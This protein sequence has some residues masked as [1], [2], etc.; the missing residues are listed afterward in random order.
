V[1]PQP[2][3]AGAIASNFSDSYV[4]P[5]NVK[6]Q[7]GYPGRSYEKF[8]DPEMYFIRTL[9]RRKLR[10]IQHYDYFSNQSK[11]KGDIARKLVVST[12]L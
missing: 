6:C 12:A 10:W 5:P 9:W 3:G 7:L 11:I 4:C 8:W 1:L 2:K